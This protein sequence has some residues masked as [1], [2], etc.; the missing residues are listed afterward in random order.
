MS[1]ACL[2]LYPS[3]GQGKREQQPDRDPQ[4]VVDPPAASD[5][6][7]DLSEALPPGTVGDGEP[8]VRDHRGSPLDDLLDRALLAGWHGEAASLGWTVVPRAKGNA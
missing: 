7:L 6:Q 1:Y 3:R 2:R 5:V 8:V 4:A